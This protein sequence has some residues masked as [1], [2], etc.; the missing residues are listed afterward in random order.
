MRGMPQTDGRVG[1]I[2][3]IMSISSVYECHMS[4]SYI[5]GISTGGADNNINHLLVNVK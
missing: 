2:I 4:P 5:R 3:F 1:L